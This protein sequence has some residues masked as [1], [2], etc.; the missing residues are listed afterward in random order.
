MKG[1]LNATAYK[2]VLDNSV[3]PTL[4]QQFGEGPF[5]FKHD[6]AHMHKVRIEMVCRDQC[7]RTWY[8]QSADLN[9]IEHLWD[10]LERRLRARPYR[11]TSEPNRTNAIVAEW[12]QVPAAMF[13][14]LLK[15]LLQ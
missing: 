9:P 11:P 5:L 1:N 3:P 2:A 7:G 14:H 4:C 8:A 6:N 10:E 12:R 13:Q 15:S